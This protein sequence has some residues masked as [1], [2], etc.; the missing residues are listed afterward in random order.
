MSLVEENCWKLIQQGL[1]RLVGETTVEYYHSGR[2]RWYEK[3]PNQHPISGRWRFMFS[4]GKGKRSTVYR[5]RLIWMLANR[6]PIPSGMFIDHVDGQRENDRANNLR[7]SD[8]STSHQQGNE[9]QMDMVAEYLSRWF[10]FMGKYGREPATPLEL[11]FV[12]EGF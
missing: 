6:A 5:N 3:K 2:R 4:Y 8:S 10:F 1:L 12:E 7:L 11:C 9:F